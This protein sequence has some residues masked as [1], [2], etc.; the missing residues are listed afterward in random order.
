M[1]IPILYLLL[2]LLHVAFKY[3][4]LARPKES[5]KS[6][7]YG[8]PPKVNWWLKQSLIYFIGLTGMKLFVLLLFILLPWLPWVGD[9]ALRWTEGNDQLQ[10]AFSMFVFPV[11]MNMVQYWIIDNFLMQKNGGKG[12]GDQGYHQVH[13]DDDDDDAHEIDDDEIVEEE[14]VVGKGSEDLPPLQEVNP[15]PLPLYDE[16]ERGRMSGEGSRRVSPAPKYEDD[17]NV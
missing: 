3:T 9:W 2:K 7:Y 14:S 6:G 8:D 17:A 12:E 4:S 13:G 11:M 5:I 16:I 1:G 15:T 10:I